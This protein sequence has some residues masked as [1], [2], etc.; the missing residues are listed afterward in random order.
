[1]TT[2]FDATPFTTVPSGISSLPTGVYGLPIT[3]PS[4]NQQG[5]IQDTTESAAW[6]CNIPQALPYQL[7]VDFIPGSPA[8]SNNELTLSYG[9]NTI[10]FLPYGAQPP[11]LS[12]AQVL[13]LVTDSQNPERGPAWFFQAPY[14]KVVILP[15]DAITAPSSNTTRQYNPHSP[16]TGAFMGQKGVAQPGDMPWFCYWN[17]TLLETFIYVNQTSSWGRSSTSSSCTTTATPTGSYEG[18]AS[19]TH[20]SSTQTSGAQSSS[21]PPPGESGDPDF[22]GIYPKVVKIQERRMPRGGQTIPPYCKSYSTLCLQIGA[23]TNVSRYPTCCQWRRNNPN[24]PE[25]HRSTRHNL[26]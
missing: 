23:V 11:V 19:G 12:Q 20:G 4:T 21:Y 15:E 2:T 26:P 22:L 10:D 13:G 9:N 6:S 7:D 5:C 25:Q 16:Q 18:N 3:T 1:M 17:G 8:L 14:N 24:K